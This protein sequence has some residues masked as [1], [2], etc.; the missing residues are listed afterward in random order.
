MNLKP[1][2]TAAVTDSFRP[3]G[4][5]ATTRES[6]SGAVRTLRVAVVYL[7]SMTF[8]AGVGAGAAT[9]LAFG[10]AVVFGLAVA[11]AVALAL[12][13]VDAGL[14]VGL[15]LLGRRSRG[16]RT[17]VGTAATTAGCTSAGAG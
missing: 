17:G 10:L 8:S 1:L 7:L 9:R 11:F 12:V 14:L 5:T 3:A 16:S 2:C 13:P 4:T 6:R 15:G